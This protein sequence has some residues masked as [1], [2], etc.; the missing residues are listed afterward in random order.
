MDMMLGRSMSDRVTVRVDRSVVDALDRLRMARAT[1][2][3][4]RQD[5][6][7]HILVDWM[8]TH[9]HLGPALTEPQQHN[10]LPPLRG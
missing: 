9:G 4:S 6:L 2:F 5:L 8:T 10:E 7:R 1:E 3:H